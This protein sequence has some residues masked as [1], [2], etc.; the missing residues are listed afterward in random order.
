MSEQPKKKRRS[1]HLI[2]DF[3]DGYAKGWSFA[4]PASFKDNLDIRWTE[5]IITRKDESGE[6]IKTNVLSWTQGTD[7]KFS[8]GDCLYDTRLA[9]D[10]NWSEALNHLRLMI[11][12]AP[13]PSSNNVS[14][15]LLRPNKAMSGIEKI[16]RLECSQK[17]FVTLLKS[18]ILNIGGIEKDLFLEY[19]H[20]TEGIL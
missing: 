4:V 11:Q 14:F 8:H 10:L 15:A 12:V 2:A 16:A 13:S 18:G 6:K 19:A 20:I 1:T 17:D 9:Y 3:K 5:R 7:Y